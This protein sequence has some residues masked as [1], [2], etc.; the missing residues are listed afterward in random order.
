MNSLQKVLGHFLQSDSVL[1]RESCNGGGC[2]QHPK[3]LGLEDIDLLLLFFK[4][5]LMEFKGKW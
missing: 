1:Q 5:M 2:Q 3:S 4:W